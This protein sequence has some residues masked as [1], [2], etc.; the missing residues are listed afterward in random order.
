MAFIQFKFGLGAGWQAD[1]EAVRATSTMLTAC[2]GALPPQTGV[3]K[4][5][6]A[7][8]SG[9]VVPLPNSSRCWHC[10]ST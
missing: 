3:W 8:S 9:N 2:T 5:D 7:L 1:T 4:P 10:S 6:T